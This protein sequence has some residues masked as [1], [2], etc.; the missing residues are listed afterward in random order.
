MS[1]DS[2]LQLQ[3]IGYLR[4][5]KTQK[6]ETGRQPEPASEDSHDLSDQIEL[7]A[8]Q[9][10]EQGLEDLDD[11]SHLWITFWFHQSQGWKPKVQPPRGIDRKVGVF[12]S[13]APYR[14]NPL[15][16]SLVPL[17]KV[18]GRI[19]WIGDSDILNGTPILDI[20]PYVAT[21]ESIPDATLGWMQFLKTP[22][23]EFEFSKLAA[24]Q[25]GW[26][27]K[28]AFH[29]DSVI[30]KQLDRDPL[31]THSKRIRILPGHQAVLSHRL[32]RIRFEV[33]SIE[34]VSGVTTNILIHQ[35]DHVFHIDVEETLTSRLSPFEIEMY[36]KFR[37]QFER[38]PLAD[39]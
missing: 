31:A 39:F 35:I 18:E 1:A 28:N 10:F 11:F 30:K 29:L 26:L 8:G 21:S 16:L 17:L 25:L 7:I 12:A 24:E 14:P 15:G 33:R 9:G 13:R 34:S 38:T 20:K 23:T 3:P 32:W 2:S 36:L 19:L 4:S 27:R 22:A 37:S 6:S 5:S